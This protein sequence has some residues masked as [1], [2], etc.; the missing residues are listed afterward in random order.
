MGF[1]DSLSKS[2]TPS[3][4]GDSVKGV[5]EQTFEKQQTEVEYDK[6]ARKYVSTERP[7]VF[8]NGQPAMSLIVVLKV[9][10][11]TNDDNGQR[12]VYINRPS[13]IFTAVASALKAAGAKEPT[14]GDTLE[15]TFTGLDPES[16]QGNA[17]MYT[18]TYAKGA[19][20][21]EEKAEAAPV[22]SV[23]ASEVSN[24]AQALLDKLAALGVK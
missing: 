19:S 20:L 6:Q 11:E 17:K 10:E 16:A 2:W 18:A 14:V 3:V 5:I 4:V 23:R 8:K 15:V 1:F 24:E 13:R 12:S 9:A 21:F 7:K 22:T